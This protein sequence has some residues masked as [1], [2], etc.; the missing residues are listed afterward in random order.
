MNTVRL[1][2]DGKQTE[3]PEG[4]TVLDAARKL[5]IDIPTLCQHPSVEP[6]AACR[7]C[8][9]DIERH[10]RKRTVASCVYPAQD[11]LTVTTSTPKLERMRKLIVELLWPA[12]TTPAKRYGLTGSRFTGAQPDCSLCGLC[13]HYCQDVAKKN[14][15]Y[16]KGRGIDR[17]VAFAPGMAKECSDCRGCFQLCSS[18]WIV[19][20]YAVESAELW[21]S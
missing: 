1:T 4:A 2:I 16:F 9:V 15:I 12:W 20:R 11:G 7:M 3:V 5:G 6:H 14:A 17:Q 13:V 18:G 21:S 8:M 19:S 10:G